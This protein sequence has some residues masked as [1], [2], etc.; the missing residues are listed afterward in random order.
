MAILIK[1]RLQEPAY[2]SENS[3]RKLPRTCKFYTDFS[4]IHT[5][6]TVCITDLYFCI[7]LLRPSSCTDKNLM[8]LFVMYIRRLRRDQVHSHI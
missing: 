4:C 1:K 2:G 5:V 8:D 6:K 7:Y 3:Y